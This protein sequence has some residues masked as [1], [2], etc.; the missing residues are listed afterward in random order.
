MKIYIIACNYDYEGWGEP[1]AAFLYKKAA[2]QYIKVKG[3]SYTEIVELKVSRRR[4]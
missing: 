1:E 3:S 4:K 2:E